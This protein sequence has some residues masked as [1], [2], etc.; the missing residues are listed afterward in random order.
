MQQSG[1][2]SIQAIYS[3]LTVQLL[4]PALARQ[5][6]VVRLAGQRADGT[7]GRAPST[8]STMSSRCTPLILDSV[9]DLLPHLT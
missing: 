4:R 7:A 9:A 6:P 5:R 2:S 1:N 3:H 8:A